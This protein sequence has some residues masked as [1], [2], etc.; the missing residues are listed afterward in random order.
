MPVDLARPLG[1][2]ALLAVAAAVVVWRRLPPPLSRRAGRLAL[3]VR[4]ALLTA[5]AL[6]LSGLQLAHTPSAQ[7]LVAVVDRSASPEGALSSERAMVQAMQ[8]A[9]QPDDNFGVI[10]FGHDATIEVPPGQHAE[11]T[12]F[13][14]QP[15][16][17]YTDVA[18]ALRLASSVLPAGTRHHLVLVSDGR[19]NLGDALPEVRL[20]HQEGVR[21]DVLPLDVVEGPEVRV[22]SVRAPSA[23]APHT[24][25]HVVVSIVSN[26]AT[27]GRL[28]VDVDGSQ[29]AD[30]PQAM[31]AGET[32]V[33]LTLPPLGAGFHTVRAN[34]DPQQDTLSE[35]DT[36]EAL[37]EV[38]GTQR[39]LVLDGHPGAGANLA[40]ALRA[41]GVDAG[42]Q[43]AELAP[44]DA[45]GISQYQ[46]VALVDVAAAQLGNDR[47]AALQQ[48]TRDLGVGLAAFGGPDTFGPGGF[49]GTPLEQALPVYM[50]ISNRSAKPPV[51]VVLVL[52]S[53]ESSAGDAVVRGAARSLVERLTPKDYIGVTDAATG[54]AVPLQAVTNRTR[55]ENAI[56]NIQYF[57]D[58]PSYE[59]Y[60]KD[61]ENALAGHPEASRHIIILGDGDAQPTSP[62]LIADIVKH[63]ITVSAVGVDVHG[64]AS[65][66]AEMKAIAGAGKG[67]FYQSESPDQVPDILLQESDNSLKP[68][69]VDKAFEPALGAPS[70]VLAGLDLNHFPGLGGYVATT[71]KP[72]A[73][74]VL[75]GPDRDPILAQWQYGLGRAVAWTSDTEGRW[76][77]T[78]LQWPDAGRLLAQM[79][80]STLPLA[81]DPQL[82]VSTSVAGDR[83]QIVVDL[84]NPPPDAAVT[85]DVVGPGNSAQAAVLAGTQP[86]RWE[87]SLPVGDVGSYVVRVT[88]T[89]H[90]RA[91]HATTAGLVVP[92]SPEYRFVGTDLRFLTELARAG[93][94]TVLRDASAVAGLPVPSVRDSVDLA[95]WL[96]A[97]AALLLPLDVAVR[98]LA[99]RPGDAAAWAEVVRRKPRRAAAPAPGLARLRQ[100][101]GQVRAAEHDASRRT[102]PAHAPPAAQHADR[103]EQAATGDTPPAAPASTAEQPAE[104]PADALATR[105]LE[106]RRRR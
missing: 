39:V 13:G 59:P 20:L 70:P 34:I 26:V 41:S 87:G 1:L 52:E 29:V 97:V 60:L 46:A 61:A 25:P 72:A 2:V 31:P 12:D 93:G 105:L 48:A 73:E 80:T 53:V 17:N 9:L 95:P 56:Q 75:A 3:G 19:Q 62:Q 27:A 78:L 101:V 43:A 67:R 99:F 69:I 8:R 98:R 74:L 14:T 51:A 38:L 10:G 40:A 22:D 83:A 7:T 66:M 81:A 36:G 16:P 24:Q 58:P 37:V 33:D 96:L 77:G 5:V 47:M 57:G 4:C 103:S 82:G 65:G 15:N 63:G 79:V 85:A 54:L 89:S 42:E 86:G 91:V 64:S 68:W 45:A 104:S 35:N 11:F 102:E 18:G 55:V 23:V 106:R 32:D 84:R 88:V 21:V 30:Q 28:R 49:A 44:H 6:A 94:G 100:R 71:I 90:G 50:Q 92:Y 76:S